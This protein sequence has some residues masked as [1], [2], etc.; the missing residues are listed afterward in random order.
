ME[1][2]QNKKSHIGIQWKMYA[3]LILFIGL[4]IGVIWFFQLQMMNYFYQVT[5]F[6]ELELS[7]T[8]ISAELGHSNRLG[9]VASDCSSEYYCDIWV[10]RIDAGGIADLIV[11]EQ[12]SG[13]SNLSF[14]IKSFPTLYQ[15]AKGNNGSYVAMFSSDHFYQNSEWVI[16]RDNESSPASH[17]IVMNNSL[18]SSALYVEIKTVGGSEYLIIQVL[19]LTPIQAM[20]K[21]LQNQALCIG[22]MLAVLALLMAW[23]MS[24]LITKPFLKM[25][26]AAKQLAE[27]QYEVDFKGEGYREINELADTLNYAAH[28]LAKTDR[29]QKELISNVSHDLRTPLTMIKG[30]GEVMRDIPG[31]N[32]A[33]NI[34]IIIDETA[35]LSDLV[36]DM[37][38]L[39]RIQSGVRKPDFQSFCLTDTVRDTLL[40]Y[41]RLTMQDG[42]HIDFFAEKDV[43]I[44]A[45]R[46]MILQVIY[47]LINNA[48]NYTGEDRRVTVRQEICGDCVRISVIDTG[49]GIPQDQ[50]AM[51]WDRYY[52]VDKV[53]K[54]ATVGTGLGLSIV[55]G[56]LEIHRARYGVMSTLGKGSIFWFEMPVYLP[57]KNISRGYQDYFEATYEGQETKHETKITDRTNA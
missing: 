5:R 44:L 42:Y 19:H 50:L 30:Y 3:I 28:E 26:T 46:R 18:R 17:P 6:N 49:E 36:N 33:E 43:E 53:H 37:L 34:Q 11:E 23:L 29:L 39:S 20:V 14:L 4:I 12:A 13:E 1:Q 22:L 57:D 16:L 24:R 35:R 2:S 32:T 15:K 52:R 51:I 10:Y 38:D 56:I 54:R 47:N 25:N 55:K 31:E 45:D 27:G 40:R 41:E 48:I 9:A 8:K 7:A 21:T